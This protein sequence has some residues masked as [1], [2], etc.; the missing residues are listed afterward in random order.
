MTT[1]IIDPSTLTEE[2][3]KI[4]REVYADN[5]D[6]IRE[7]GGKYDPDV[8]CEVAENR[9]LEWFFGKDFFKKGE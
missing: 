7:M 3:K 1:P 5:K 8:K 4:I 9:L 6:F 2:Q